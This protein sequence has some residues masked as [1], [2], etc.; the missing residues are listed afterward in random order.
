MARSLLWRLIVLMTVGVLLKHP[1]SIIY[2]WNQY[3]EE[4]LGKRRS[5][6]LSV[7]NANKMHTRPLLIV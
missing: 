7:C 6:R 4:I 2:H 1:R 5:I 3:D